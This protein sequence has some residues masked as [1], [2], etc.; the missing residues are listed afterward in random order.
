MRYALRWQ[1]EGAL[2]ILAAL[3]ASPD[4][5]A[6]RV[7]AREACLAAFESDAAL[8][9]ALAAL[10]GDEAARYGAAEVYAAN[11]GDDSVGPACEAPLRQ[12]FE[13]EDDE[14]R[15]EAGTCFQGLR[16]AAL[17]RH[18]DMFM[19]FA[20]SKALTE[21]AHDVLDAILRIDGPLPDVAGAM[22]LEILNRAGSEAGDIATAWSAHMPDISAIAV[23]LNAF[24]IGRAS[25]RERV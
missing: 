21:D 12:L 17:T 18:L 9:L 6:R 23:R 4:A 1:P 8:P 25:C 7:A 16:G 14:V 20:S 24:E 15:R 3:F 5:E 11:L 19:G 13:D 2:D 22:G 10:A